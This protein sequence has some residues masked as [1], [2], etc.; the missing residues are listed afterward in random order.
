MVE[1]PRDNLRL[2]IAFAIRSGMTAA[3]E[4]LSA[5]ERSRQ[6]SF[7]VIGRLARQLHRS[8]ILITLTSIPTRV[9]SHR[10]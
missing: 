6:R 7:D 3:A 8:L 1:A 4:S 5:I 2:S 9:G 10:G